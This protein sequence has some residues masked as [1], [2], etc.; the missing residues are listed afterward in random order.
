M[1]TNT[2]SFDVHALQVFLPLTLGARLVLPP[3]AAHTDGEA[4]CDLI[5]RHRVTVREGQDG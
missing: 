3:P 2:I 4:I 1:L 5:A